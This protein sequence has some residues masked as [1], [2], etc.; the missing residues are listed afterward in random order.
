M[1]ALNLTELTGDA[2]T[3]AV[4]TCHN[5]PSIGCSAATNLVLGVEAFTKG[6]R[7]GDLLHHI[8]DSYSNLA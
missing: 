7:L 4:L 3:G 6:I 8:F 1:S 2:L 5:Q